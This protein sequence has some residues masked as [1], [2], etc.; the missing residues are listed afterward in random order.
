M[1][2]DGG[3]GWKHQ[4]GHVWHSGDIVPWK[5]VRGCRERVQGWTL[6]RSL[7]LARLRGWVEQV[8]KERA[9]G[10]LGVR[11]A[12]EQEPAA[13]G[14]AAERFERSN[15]CPWCFPTWRSLLTLVALEGQRRAS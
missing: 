8:G 6:G 1:H 3:L 15:K 7:R 2:G 10:D 9:L 13:P 5:R 14:K 12:E 11:T 4:T